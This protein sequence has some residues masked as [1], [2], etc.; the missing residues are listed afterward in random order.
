MKWTRKY[1]NFPNTTLLILLEETSLERFEELKSDESFILRMKSV[2][3]KFQKVSDG[4][5]KKVHE[6]KIAYFSMEY[7]LHSSL[8][9]YS[10]G[11]GI[12]AGDYLKEASD[13]K[14]DM[15]GIGLLYRYGYFKQIISSQG[16]QLAQY[17]A[18]H[19]S[20]IP[21]QPVMDENGDWVTIDIEMPG[22]VVFAHVWSVNI[23]SIKLYLLDTDYDANRDSDRFITHHLYGG[24]NENRLKQEMVLGLGGIRLLEKLGVK[25]D[26]YHCNEGHAAFI[27]LE[28]IRILMEDSKLT[29]P[30]A[31]EI[32]RASTL[33]TTHTPVPAGHDSFHEE[34]F[35]LYMS[36]MALKMGIS[37]E[38]FLFLGK[39]SLSED[40]FNMSYLAAN[41]SQEVNGVSRLHGDVSREVF[42]KLYKGFLPE[43]LENINYVT[44]GVHYPTWAAP[45]WKVIHE[46]F[47]KLKN[48]QK[49]SPDMIRRPSRAPGETFIRFRISRYG[50]QNQN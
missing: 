47:L 8:K 43:E 34:L 5:E 38:E 18:E 48:F 6:P 29:F 39:A 22:R 11:L 2:E 4:K 41:L 3:S 35:K 13:S 20:K 9:I 17:D 24:D 46:K 32:V 25:P 36:K 31:K 37:T 26:I 30:E 10:G 7:G 21:I 14:V 27:G 49:I 16:E 1:G 40:H 12:L 23:G 44:N 42:A 19:F 15:T 33:F 45:D 28:R 50:K